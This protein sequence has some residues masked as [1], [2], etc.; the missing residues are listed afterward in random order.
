MDFYQADLSLF[1][2]L[3]IPYQYLF[4]AYFL[5]IRHECMAEILNKYKKYDLISKDSSL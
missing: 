5:Q 3:S 4:P 2:N 1:F